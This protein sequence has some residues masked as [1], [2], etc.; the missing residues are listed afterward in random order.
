MKKSE[1]EK[2]NKILK[3]ALTK[4][5]PVVVE[6]FWDNHTAGSLPGAGYN[7]KCYHKLPFGWKQTEEFSKWSEKLK[8]ILAIS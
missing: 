3:D 4:C 2:E 7:H 6:A 1:L 5:L 8:K